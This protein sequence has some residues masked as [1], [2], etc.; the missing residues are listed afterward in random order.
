MRRG[1]SRQCAGASISPYSSVAPHDV[2]VNCRAAERGYPLDDALP[3]HPRLSSGAGP[4]TVGQGAHGPA[5][6]SRLAYSRGAT[7]TAYPG[8]R[9]HA[10]KTLEVLPCPST[11]G[12]SRC[13][14]STVHRPM[15]AHRSRSRPS[16]D[17]SIPTSSRS[18]LSRPTKTERPWRTSTPAPTRHVVRIEDARRPT[19]PVQGGCGHARS[20]SARSPDD[21]LDGD[22]LTAPSP[23][24]ASKA[25]GQRQVGIP[26][27]STTGW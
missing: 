10:G 9:T 23:L 19:G 13:P 5:R 8:I 26:L 21:L 2:C 4:R 7:I 16:L 11:N 15:P 22:P 3:H 24:R 17:R 20:V 27:R 6:G 25:I 18:P 12:P 1:G 14:S